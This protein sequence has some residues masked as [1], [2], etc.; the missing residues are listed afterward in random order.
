MYNYI[1]KSVLNNHFGSSTDPCC[2]QNCVIMKPAV[3]KT[4]RCINNQGLSYF[5][6]KTYMYI[7]G[8]ILEK[9]FR[10]MH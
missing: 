2:I 7:T 3:I 1:A 8:L 4:F 10:D 6:I 5:K 9:N